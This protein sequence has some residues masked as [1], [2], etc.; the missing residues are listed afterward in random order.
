MNFINVKDNMDLSRK[1]ADIMLLKLRENKRACFGLGYS[2]FALDAYKILAS[3]IKRSG[4]NVSQT[5]IVQLEEWWRI[6]N[7]KSF[8]EIIN[9]SLVDKTNIEPENVISFD[10]DSFDP[11]VECER[12]RDILRS[13]I[14][15]IDICVLELGTEGSINCADWSESMMPYVS[16]SKINPYSLRMIER[17]FP[18]ANPKRAMTL[19]IRDLLCA[20][21]IIVLIS[22]KDKSRA[23]KSLKEEKVSMKYPV[24]FLHLASNVICL[25]D[26]EY[27]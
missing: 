24:S 18:S 9:N 19:G 3:N 17:M 8:A 14:K 5:K 1:C 10:S 6:E 2:R 4:I 12:V 13:E 26:Q 11:D 27:I 23:L 20:E 21:T 25:V 16:S 7:E 15:K 22:G